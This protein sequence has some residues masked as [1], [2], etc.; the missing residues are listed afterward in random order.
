LRVTSCLL[1]GLIKL[2]KIVISNVY[3]I[4]ELR[5]AEYIISFFRNY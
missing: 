3:N 2:V 4:K 5:V 1:I